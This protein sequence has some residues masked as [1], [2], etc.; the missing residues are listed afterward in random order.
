MSD[1]DTIIFA[2]DRGD[3]EVTVSTFDPNN[4]A[5]ANILIVEHDEDCAD[6]LEALLTDLP[7][8]AHVKTAGTASAAFELLDD[9]DD[10]VGFSADTEVVAATP[11]IIFIG[12]HQPDTFTSGQELIDTVTALRKRVPNASIV[13][14]C[15]YPNQYRDTLGE[16]VD[17]CIRK[18]TSA[19]ELRELIDGLRAT[20][21][22]QY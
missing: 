9:T 6:A 20:R 18:D 10:V 16:L 8:V 13:L 19:R 7:G 21:S 2:V 22:A 1:L 5:I 11:D 3:N 12:A 14:L 17:G 15:V 4:T